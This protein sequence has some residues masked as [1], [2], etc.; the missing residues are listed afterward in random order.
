MS[1]SGGSTSHAELVRRLALFQIAEREIATLPK[2]HVGK[3]KHVVLDKSPNSPLQPRVVK[4]TTL[5]ELR[6]LLSIP[7]D[8]H[9]AFEHS[10]AQAAHWKPQSPALQKALQ[11]GGALHGTKLQ[12]VHPEDRQHLQYVARAAL[13]NHESAKPYQHVVEWFLREID[14]QILAWA[15]NEIIVDDGG[16]LELNNGVNVLVANRIHIESTARI[17]GYGTLSINCVTLFGS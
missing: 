8:A 11:Q 13:S 5:A 15:A 4:F 14:L 3:H 17:V 1:Q 10:V 6:Q 9:A 2:L 16:V 12:A 7:D